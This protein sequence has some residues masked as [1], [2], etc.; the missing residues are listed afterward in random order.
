[1][2]ARD[3]ETW[4]RFLQVYG[5]LV[6]E[7]IG[8]AEVNPSAV[9][10]IAQDIFT[11]V[12]TSFNNYQ[13]DAKRSG[14]LRR[15]MWGIAKNKIA[16][17]QRKDAQQVKAGGGLSFFRLINQ[18]PD[19]PFEDSDPGSQ[20]KTRMQLAARALAILQTDFAPP[21]WQAFWRSVIDGEK[22]S[23]IAES[24]NMTAVAVRQSRFRVLRRLREELGEDLPST[25]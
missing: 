25:L 7:W 18:L 17:W 12:A 20:H 4:M 1:M 6:Y 2:A 15:W 19:V 16:D 3:D 13:H 8:R 21:T 24:L 5:P 22:T 11:A 23:E 14:S 10:D 9:D